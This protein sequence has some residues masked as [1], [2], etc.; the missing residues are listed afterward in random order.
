V[1]AWEKLSNFPLSR[2][3][4]AVLQRRL[5]F[6]NFA[7]PWLKINP[8]TSDEMFDAVSGGYVVI[9]PGHNVIIG[10]ADNVAEFTTAYAFA[11][12][13]KVVKLLDESNQ[14]SGIKTPDIEIDNL[15]CDIK[16][17]TSQ[18]TI[19]Q[20]VMGANAPTGQA[21]NMIFTSAASPEKVNGGIQAAI[22]TADPAG[23]AQYLATNVG[24]VYPDGTTKII[25]II[26]FRN[27]TRF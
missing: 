16:N 9:H 20:K 10:N 11:K 13:N 6:D 17:T 14:G 19:Q 24:Y 8:H 15:I 21:P 5:D 22:N 26:D 27:G 23:T 1:K 25:S 18:T 7:P 12:D 4:L 3:K 2:V